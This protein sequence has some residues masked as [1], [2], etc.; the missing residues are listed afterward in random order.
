M[1]GEPSARTQQFYMVGGQQREIPQRA[2]ECAMEDLI[3]MGFVSG[4]TPEHGIR[5]HKQSHPVQDSCR[6]EMPDQSL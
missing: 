1:V 4:P 3:G 5:H 2:E 6:G